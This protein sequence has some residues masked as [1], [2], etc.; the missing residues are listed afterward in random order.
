MD[1]CA[2]VCV[3]PPLIQWFHADGKYQHFFAFVKRFRGLGCTTPVWTL[4]FTIKLQLSNYWHCGKLQRLIHS[5]SDKADSLK[6]FLPWK[7]AIWVH[8]SVVQG[9]VCHYLLLTS[10]GGFLAYCIYPLL[11]PF[12]NNSKYQIECIGLIE[13]LVFQLRASPVWLYIYC[14]SFQKSL[15]PIDLNPEQERWS[16]VKM[17]RFMGPGTFIDHQT[18]SQSVTWAE[19]SCSQLE[20]YKS[21]VLFCKYAH[22]A[23]RKQQRNVPVGNEINA[24]MRKIFILS[25]SFVSA[26]QTFTQ[27][28]SANMVNKGTDSVQAA[29]H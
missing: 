15:L 28:E 14:C 16:P 23:A 24:K 8:F 9:S 29:H 3:L 25:L 27:L 12:F 13:M 10:I 1:L 22:K 6:C 4:E 7:P 20:T 11:D 26:S 17:G 21:P 2:G 5:L 18:T 19:T